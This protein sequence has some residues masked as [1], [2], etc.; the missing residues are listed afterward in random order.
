KDI[1]IECHMDEAEPYFYF[2]ADRIEQVFTNLISNAIRHCSPEG[3]VTVTVRTD[4]KGL[5]VSVFNT[6][7][8]IPEE[9]L[10][11]VFERFYKG[12]KARTRGRSGTGLGLA[13]A[14][15][16]VEGHRGNISVQSKS[17]HGTTFSFFI[18][19]RKK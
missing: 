12:D 13:I 18:P 16:I 4:V 10:P 5:H 19:R 15:N 1:H 17:G 7:E 2:D 14:K 9:D 8:P 6:G 3:L 11:F